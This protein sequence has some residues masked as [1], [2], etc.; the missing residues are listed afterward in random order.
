MG[1]HGSEERY[2]KL[3]EVRTV[4]NREDRKDVRRNTGKEGGGEG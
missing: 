1:K 4:R 3:K 2:E